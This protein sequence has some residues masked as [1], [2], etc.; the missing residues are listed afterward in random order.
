MQE[1]LRVR[2]Q[3]A[4]ECS[5]CALLKATTQFPEPPQHGHA[6]ARCRARPVPTAPVANDGRVLP[7]SMELRKDC[8]PS[9]AQRHVPR[10]FTARKE[11]PSR[12]SAVQ[13]T[14]TARWGRRN[15]QPCPKASS[16]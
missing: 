10:A 9:S 16:R 2:G 7:A 8:A 11:P 1:K 3:L 6:Q 14:T 4:G 5:A 13:Q 15:R 12:S